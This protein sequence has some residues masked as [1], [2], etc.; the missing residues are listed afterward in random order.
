M[1]TSI[2]GGRVLVPADRLGASEPVTSH[3][4]RLLANNALH[5]A[6][7]KAHCL[8][9]WT[10]PR[11]SLMPAGHTGYRVPNPVSTSWTRLAVWG[12]LPVTLRANRVA[13]PVRLE[14]AGATSSALAS[15][16]FGAVLVP[17][18]EIGT[19]YVEDTAFTAGAGVIFAATASTTPAWLAA[20]TGSKYFVRGAEPG[21]RTRDT[22]LDEG[23]E[24]TTVETVETYL[25][26]YAKTSSI[27]G[28]PRLY[29]VHLSEHV[30]A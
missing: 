26:V 16:T 11:T 21:A 18:V 8:V 24:P 17:S 1:T 15:V 25:V 28:T 22:I 3:A 9:N 5:Y 30:G 13:Y 20:A 4:A 6:D 23:G 10:A 14:L 2:Y 27:D 12:P 7:Q 29:G 19:D